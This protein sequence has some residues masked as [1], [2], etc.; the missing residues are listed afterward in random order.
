MRHIKK[1]MS[2]EMAAQQRSRV[3]YGDTVIVHLKTK[4]IPCVVSW[5]RDTG[6]DACVLC[7]EDCSKYLGKYVFGVSTG[8]SLIPIEETVE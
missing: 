1:R 6:C 8:M 2:S 4:E 3:R 5:C 7:Q